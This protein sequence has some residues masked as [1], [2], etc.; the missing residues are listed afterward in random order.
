VEDLVHLCAGM[1]IDTGVDL[2][3]YLAVVDRVV[4][5]TGRPATSFVTRGGTREQLA[6][7]SWPG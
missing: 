7:A 2:A 4:A 1:G 3:A 5:L 6:R